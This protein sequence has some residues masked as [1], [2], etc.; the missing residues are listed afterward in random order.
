[1]G[2]L[3]FFTGGPKKDPVHLTDDNFK[4]TVLA[5][6]SAWLV[7]FW[8]PNCP[9]CDKMVPTIRILTAK[10]HG[11]VKFGEVQTSGNPK[12]T[13]SFGVKG[14]PTLIFF[15]EGRIVERLTGFQTQAY[16]EEVVAAHFAPAGPPG[17]S[18]SRTED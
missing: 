16:L 6:P 18:G 15:K 5:D 10:Y 2:V 7:D 11:K 8:G 3:D 17:G 13:A 1:M 4:D 12:V 9:W 14:T